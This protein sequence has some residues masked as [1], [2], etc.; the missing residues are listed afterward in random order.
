MTEN[1]DKEQEKPTPAPDEQGGFIFSSSLKIS[2]PNSGE[3]LVQKRG[4]D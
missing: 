4:D 2:D 3:I 1:K